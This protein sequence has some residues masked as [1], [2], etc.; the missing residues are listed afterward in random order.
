MTSNKNI[1]SISINENKQD[2]K[3]Q[4]GANRGPSIW[5]QVQEQC[6]EISQAK[7]ISNQNQNHR[8]KKFFLNQNQKS[9]VSKWSQ[10]QNHNQSKYER[11]SMGGSRWGA[12]G[13][14]APMP[15]PCPPA[16]PPIF[17]WTSLWCPM[18]KW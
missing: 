8:A 13:A 3:A 14:A 12:G 7:V 1:H 4:K 17:G 15:S 2:N 6:W 16:A 18:M 11:A 5:V 9:P 10:S